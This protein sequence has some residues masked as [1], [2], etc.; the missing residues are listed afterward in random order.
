LINISSAPR[1]KQRFFPSAVFRFAPGEGTVSAV[2]RDCTVTVARDDERKCS[3]I[4]AHPRIFPDGTPAGD[5]VCTRKR[6]SATRIKTLPE[7]PETRIAAMRVTRGRTF[8]PVC[9]LVG[10]SEA[11][12]SCLIPI[13]VSTSPLPLPLSLSFAFIGDSSLIK[14]SNSARGYILIAARSQIN[15]PSPLFPHIAVS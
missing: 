15:P 6:E 14:L 2:L 13:D 9:T 10:A 5:A 11:V 8:A 1:R 12:L 7:K 4:F 3:S